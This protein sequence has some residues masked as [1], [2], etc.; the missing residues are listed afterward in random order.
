MAKGCGRCCRER[1][2]KCTISTPTTGDDE[3]YQH[4]YDESYKSTND[5]TLS[6]P[7]GICAS[8]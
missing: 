4:T 8:S 2:S 5:T 3:S 1:I 6:E 7:E